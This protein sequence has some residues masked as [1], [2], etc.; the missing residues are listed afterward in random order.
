MDMKTSDRRTLA[1]IGGLFYLLIIAGGLFAE[2][3][4]RQQLVIFGDPA[5]SIANI[6]DQAFLY[7]LGFAVHLAYVLV[8]VP[9]A[10]IF[11]WLLKGVSLHL[12][13]LALALNLVAI[14]TEA[15]NLLNQLAV[16]D[17]LTDP[18]LTGDAFPLT[19]MAYAYGSLFSTGFGISL[20]F[21][22]GFCLVLGYLIIRSGF[23]PRLLGALMM[24]AGGCYLINSFSLFLS[25]EFAAHL[26]P[27]ILLPCLL[28]ELS[29]AL[30]LLL[31]GV[32]DRASVIARVGH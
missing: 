15:T 18:G 19:E 9:L 25:P 10:L 27:W 2:A 5:A 32:S 11:Y 14:A 17:L 7:R 3:Y 24:L 28:A 29:L 23:L 20:V 22:G 31:K 6:L 30:W 8:A 26:F 13:Q 21:F 1:R 16:V 4:V 12:A